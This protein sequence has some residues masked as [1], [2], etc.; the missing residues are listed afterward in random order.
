MEIQIGQ[1]D[2]DVSESPTIQNTAGTAGE[3]MKQ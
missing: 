1:K 3:D 2:T